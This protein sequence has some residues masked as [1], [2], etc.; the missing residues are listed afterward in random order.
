MLCTLEATA[1][2]RKVGSAHSLHSWWIPCCLRYSVLANFKGGASLPLD[3]FVS[4]Q[5]ILQLHPTY[6][7]DHKIL[8]VISKM[9]KTQTTNAVAADRIFEFQP[10]YYSLCWSKTKSLRNCSGGWCGVK[11]CVSGAAWSDTRTSEKIIWCI[12]GTYICTV[13]YVRR[14]WN[15]HAHSS[16]AHPPTYVF[17]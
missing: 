14:N 17:T 2:T 9:M 6:Q 7:G 16:A 3:P 12:D 8:V 11:T 5:S 4:Q 1:I 13:K 15:E 10:D